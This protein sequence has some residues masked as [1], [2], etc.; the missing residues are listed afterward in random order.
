[1]TGVML[2]TTIKLMIIIIIIIIIIKIIRIITIIV[3]NND[4]AQ[5]PKIAPWGQIL[6]KPHEISGEYPK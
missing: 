6:M 1:M 4:N 3:S 5:Q 2:V